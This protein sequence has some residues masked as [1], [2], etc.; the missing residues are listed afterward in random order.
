MHY[1]MN[2]TFVICNNVNHPHINYSEMQHFTTFD[3]EVK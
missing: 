2:K 3:N 1:P